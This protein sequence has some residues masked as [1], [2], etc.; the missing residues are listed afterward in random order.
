MQSR[1]RYS[2]SSRAEGVEEEP[3]NSGLGDGD[4]DTPSRR[5][6]SLVCRAQQVAILWMT[7]PQRV[8]C[9]DAHTPTVG[10][11]CCVHLLSELV[12]VSCQCVLGPC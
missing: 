1:D 12:C 5:V 6:F 7:H 11:Q 10:L 2:A 8:A 4:L 3:R 9:L